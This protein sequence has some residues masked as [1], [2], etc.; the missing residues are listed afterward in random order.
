MKSS[1]PSYKGLVPA[2]ARAS[3]A[4]RGASA[5]TGTRAEVLLA[6]ALSARGVRFR[7]NVA[8]LP[9]K[10][11]LVHTRAGV[12]VFCDGDFWHGRNL[13]SRLRKL[14]RGHNSAYWMLKIETNVRRDK[15]VRARLRRAGWLPIRCWETD[16]LADPRCVANKIVAAIEDRLRIEVA[17]TNSRPAKIRRG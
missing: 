14:G 5:K 17:T 11:D 8:E 7:K 12:A 1:P 2:S 10:P 15:A 6:R 16:V 4:A 3:K 13:R 9:G